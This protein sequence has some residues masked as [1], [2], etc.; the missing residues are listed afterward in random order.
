M[1]YVSFSFDLSHFSL[2]IVKFHK[3]VISFIVSE[4][5][6]TVLMFQ[7]CTLPVSS[8]LVP[9]TAVRHLLQLSHIFSIL[10]MQHFLNFLCAYKFQDSSLIFTEGL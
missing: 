5:W 1:P 9:I 6:S 10:E 7:A 3:S 8:F 2:H 4:I